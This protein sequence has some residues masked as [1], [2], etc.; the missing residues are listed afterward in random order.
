MDPWHVV[1]FAR[2]VKLASL[3]VKPDD[4]LKAM[5]KCRIL[6]HCAPG[7]PVRIMVI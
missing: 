1:C 7:K 6:G 2:H 5:L 4:R 3:P